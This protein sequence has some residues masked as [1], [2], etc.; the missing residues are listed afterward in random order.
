[1]Q[2]TGDQGVLMEGLVCSAGFELMFNSNPMLV[3]SSHGVVM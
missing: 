2:C 3:N 1:V